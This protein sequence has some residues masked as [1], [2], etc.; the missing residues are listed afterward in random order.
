MTERTHVIGSSSL[1]CQYIQRE[2]FYALTYVNAK[3]ALQERSLT[4]VHKALSAYQP[5][6]SV[7]AIFDRITASM[8]G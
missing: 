8:F 7:G 4:G 2:N 3:M 1:D 5:M 6:T